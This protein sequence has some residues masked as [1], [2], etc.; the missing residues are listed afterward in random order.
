[1]FGENYKKIQANNVQT[2]RTEMNGLNIQII[3]R[4][5]DPGWCRRMLTGVFLGIM[6]ASAGGCFSDSGTNP[7]PVEDPGTNPPPPPPS[8]TGQQYTVDQSGGT[9]VFQ[10]TI[11]DVTLTLVFPAGALDSSTVIT[12]DHAQTFPSG[13]GLVAGAVFDIGPD[14]LVFNIPVELSITYGPGLIGGLAED[15][16]RI[17][18]ASG[19]DWMPLLGSAD[20]VN[21]VVS[22]SI[23]SLSIFGLKTIAAG[24]GGA[25][26]NPNATLDW[27][28]TRVFGG[29]CSQ[30]HT[31]AG[32][33]MGVDWSSASAS[34][35][36]VGRASSEIPTLMVVDSGNPAA[37]YVIWKVEGAGPN[38]E[39]ISGAQMPLSNPPLTA[40]AIQNM[41]DWIVDGTPGCQTQGGGDTG[42]GDTGGGGTGGGGTGPDTW[43]TIQADI[44]Q[45]RCVIC[46]NNSPAAPMGLSWEADQFDTVV[47]NGRM[48]G[49]IASMKIIEPG[50]SAASYVIWKINGQGPAGEAIAG[51]RMPASGPPFL[52]EAEIDRIT[53]WIDAGAPGAG[54]GDTGGGT[55]GGDTGGG[56]TGGGGANPSD[57]IPTWYGIQANIL[58]QLCTL[59]HSGSNPPM[60]L[61]W[62]VNQFD[63]IV[64]NGRMS[65][66]IPS[67][68]IV[69]PG[70][71]GS[72]YMFWKINGQGPAGEAIQGVR[73]PAT[74]IP[75]DQALIDVIEQWILDGAPLGVPA[76]ADAGG[77]SEPEF[78]VGSWMYVWSESLQVCTLCHSPTPSSP[79]CGVD[80]DCPPKDVVLTADNYFGVVDDSTVEPFDLDGSKLWERVTED[81]ADKRMPFGLDPLTNRQ[82]TIIRDW[83][84]DG[85]PFCPTGAVCP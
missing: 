38:G 59:C 81:D 20:S 58:E 4:Y 73:M 85:A 5:V 76:D 18:K 15:D 44:L 66:E 77:P 63:A 53:A 14:G 39:A 68:A 19:T 41:R 75:L 45:A 79:R 49:Q 13:V 36:N 37:S 3:S 2:G 31:G 9:I 27:L 83:I 1:M 40:E 74:G 23:D 16:L 28:Q 51:A 48:S 67:M 84:M 64:T 71:P 25:S 32:A 82:L 70:D 10:S 7:T 56:G 22:A 60:G 80:F 50:D 35:S 54:G 61:S 42:G 47:T 12:I 62:E 55:G 29:V 30:C 57:I 72:S 6:I 11:E 26:G 8:G 43:E 17:H 24:G 34:C 78:P 69:Q 21:K 46:H 65:S 33:P 52:G